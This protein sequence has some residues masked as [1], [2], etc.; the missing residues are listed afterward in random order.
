MRPWDPRNDVTQYESKYQLLTKTRHKTPM[1]RTQSIVSVL[2]PG[3]LLSQAPRRSRKTKQR[4]QDSDTSNNAAP[5]LAKVPILYPTKF[6]TP[7]VQETRASSSSLE[8]ALAPLLEEQRAMSDRIGKLNHTIE[9]PPSSFPHQSL[10]NCHRFAC[11]SRR[12][13]TVTQ[14][15]TETL[16]C[17]SS[18]W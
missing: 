10:I 4:S 14:I 8:A 13:V 16:S 7:C 15:S 9:V 12:N 6:T 3:P 17:S 11:T 1:M 18:W 2:A 5:S